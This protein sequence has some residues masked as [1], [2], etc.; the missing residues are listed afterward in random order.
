MRR[1]LFTIDSFI[2]CLF[3]PKVSVWGKHTSRQVE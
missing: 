2:T 1:Q 3:G